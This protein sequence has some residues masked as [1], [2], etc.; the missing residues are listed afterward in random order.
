[1]KQ[2][3]GSN[4]YVS[5]HPFQKQLCAWLCSVQDMLLWTLVHSPHLSIS[6]F[7]SLRIVRSSGEV[8]P[9]VHSTC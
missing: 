6:L 2:S 9:A 1:M 7:L 4:V 8:G 5:K 3:T